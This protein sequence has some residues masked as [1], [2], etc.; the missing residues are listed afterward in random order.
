MKTFALAVFGICALTQNGAVATNSSHNPNCTI[1][2]EGFC[3]PNGYNKHQQPNPKETTNVQVKFTVEQI[4]SVNDHDFTISL[5]MFLSLYWRDDRLPYIG[6][7]PNET[8]PADIPLSMEWAE[9][10]W[11]PD[12]YVRKMQDIKKPKILQ[13]FGCESFF[14]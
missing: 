12:I 7:N 6:T 14:Y 4:T 8:K 2:T 3:I 9:N 1:V 10:I 5:N 11:L 13:E